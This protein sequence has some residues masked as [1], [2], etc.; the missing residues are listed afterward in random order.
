ML[1]CDYC[2][3][4]SAPCPVRC[5][6]HLRASRPDAQRCRDGVRRRGHCGP[7]RG[8][9]LITPYPAYAPRVSPDRGRA[10]DRS[11]RSRAVTGAAGHRHPPTKCQDGGHRGE[12]VDTAPSAEPVGHPHSRSILSIMRADS[13]S[14]PRVE[15]MRHGVRSGL[16][17]NY[18]HATLRRSSSVTVS[19]RVLGRSVVG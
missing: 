8:D 15:W 5:A 7:W 16:E 3:L 10:P 12:A 13:P 6:G 17:L 18:S 9:S 19:T 4:H 1:G 11:L 14:V 2:T